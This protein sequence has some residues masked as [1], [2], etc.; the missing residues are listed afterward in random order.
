MNKLNGL[1]HHPI[2]NGNAMLTVVFESPV[3]HE[4]YTDKTRGISHLIEHILCDSYDDLS[5]LFEVECVQVNASTS[6]SDV[7]FF[8]R[9]TK[10]NIAKYGLEYIKRIV[11]A[12]IPIDVF[13]REKATVYNEINSNLHQPRRVYSYLLYEVML[14]TT[15]QSGRLTDIDDFTYEQVVKFHKEHFSKPSRIVYISA[16]EPSTDIVDYCDTLSFEVSSKNRYFVD[17]DPEYPKLGISVGEDTPQYHSLFSVPDIKLVDEPKPYILDFISDALSNGLKSPLYQ[18]LR[19]KHQLCYSCGMDYIV[20]SS[21]EYGYLNIIVDCDPSNW[22]EIDE[23]I[24]MIMVNPDE[25]LTPER[26]DITKKSIIAVRE[27]KKAIITSSDKE[28]ISVLQG[29]FSLDDNIESITYAEVLEYCKKYLV[30]K[31]FKALSTT[32]LLK[33]T[34]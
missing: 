23:R 33:Q 14:K 19:E 13:E 28:Y 6:T 26:F 9:G 11:N 20:E 30:R 4:A 10:A 34:K 17:V 2:D 24:S 1:I 31:N 7:S 12:T 27:Y 16:D 8:I 29:K 18:E 25:Y 21:C 5:E 22:D 15:T 32:S 3:T